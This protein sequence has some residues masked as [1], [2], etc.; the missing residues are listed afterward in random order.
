MKLWVLFV[1]SSNHVCEMLRISYN[2][3]QPEYL[4]NT[5]NCQLSLPIVIWFQSAPKR[6]LRLLKPIWII[7][8]A[9]NNYWIKSGAATPSVCLRG[10]RIGL[11]KISLGQLIVG[12]IR[13]ESLQNSII[14]AS[15]TTAA[16]NDDDTNP[17]WWR[18]QHYR[19]KRKSWR[20]KLI[21]DEFNRV[22]GIVTRAFVRSVGGSIK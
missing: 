20:H 16:A 7:F 21:K 2:P 14:N 15:S 18:G 11:T 12:I 4:N 22:K 9:N 10:V 19:E 13:L 8:N 5:F 1:W 3:E 6:L 17:Q